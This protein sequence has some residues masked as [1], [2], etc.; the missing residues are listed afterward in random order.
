MRPLPRL[1]AV[2]TDA[3]CRSPDFSE[4]TAAL[5][6]IGPALGVLVRAPGS[7]TAEQASFA[8]R[9]TALARPAEATVLVH[10]RP[11]LARAV[12]AD[13]VQLRQDDLAP[14]DARRVFLSGWIGVAIHSRAEAAAAIE[15]GA[16]FVVAGNVF[17]T[18]SHPARPARGV[19][20]LTEICSLGRPVIAIGGVTP[21]RAAELQRA[22]AW[23]A[24]A[25]S[26]LW[27]APDPTAAGLGILTA[28]NGTT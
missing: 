24:A 7:P 20:W 28:W 16:D 4:R 26:A 3:V 22:G 9:V 2:T 23:G 25:I 14:A 11:D 10:G 1:L 13:G 19:G 6:R 21:D 17:E 18:S 5:V 8:E 27:E 15:A 12:D